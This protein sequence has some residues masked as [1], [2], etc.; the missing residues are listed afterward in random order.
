MLDSMPSD[1]EK[2]IIALL[3]NQGRLSF[4]RFSKKIHQKYKQH[5]QLI[6]K[7]ILFSIKNDFV[8]SDM[9]VIFKGID[10]TDI[11]KLQEFCNFLEADKE[12]IKLKT[13][14]LVKKWTRMEDH[15][16]VA[17]IKNRNALFLYKIFLNYN[18]PTKLGLSLRRTSFVFGLLISCGGMYINSRIELASYAGYEDLY[19]QLANKKVNKKF[20]IMLTKLKA[21]LKF[22]YPNSNVE[23]TCKNEIIASANSEFKEFYTV[24]QINTMRF[25]VVQ[26]LCSAE[27]QHCYS[28]PV[29]K[30]RLQNVGFSAELLKVSL[31]QLPPMLPQEYYQIPKFL[32]TALYKNPDINLHAWK[33]TELRT[34]YQYPIESL[35]RILLLPTEDRDKIVSIFRKKYKAENSKASYPAKFAKVMKLISNCKFHEMILLKIPSLD[36]LDK[37]MQ[38][39]YAGADVLF[40]MF[41]YKNLCNFWLQKFSSLENLVA[42]LTAENIENKTIKELLASNAGKQTLANG[43]L[44][45]LNNRLKEVVSLQS[46]DELMTY[47]AQCHA[48]AMEYSQSSSNNEPEKQKQLLE[49]LIKHS[50]DLAAEAT[51]LLKRKAEQDNN[52]A[53]HKEFK[54]S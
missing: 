41:T 40:Y 24:K 29:H 32:I 44:K 34:I 1:I 26:V 53:P 35:P 11:Q 22:N 19:H 10:I 14:E 17:D 54:L 3:D 51:K 28:S 27:M 21:D 8:M 4:F 13:I 46:P 20:F 7:V 43:T 47:A 9:N 12:T 48:L 2:S 18:N 38:V 45:D 39:K 33:L 42:R 16:L 25:E 15:E 52:P 30:D 23:P 49:A 50:Q 5:L 37:L 31:L 6:K 36:I